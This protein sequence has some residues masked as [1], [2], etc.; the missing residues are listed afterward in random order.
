MAI[1]KG[2]FDVEILEDLIKQGYQGQELLEKFISTREKV[3]LAFE[4]MMQDLIEQSKGES[5][6][7][8]EVFGDEYA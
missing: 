7:M 8:Q 3:P 5:Y 4:K 6:T 1:H 2:E